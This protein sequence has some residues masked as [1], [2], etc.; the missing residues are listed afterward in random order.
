[1]PAMSADSGW[2]WPD[3]RWHEPH[4]MAIP[5]SPLTDRGA[6][7]GSSGNQSGGFAVP[8]ILAASDS[9]AL[10]GALT[11]PSGRTAVRGILAGV[12]YARSGGAAGAVSAGCP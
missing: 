9:F 10:P 11:M 3:I 2:P 6:A 1:M 12:V 8:A 7:G 5:G 4:A